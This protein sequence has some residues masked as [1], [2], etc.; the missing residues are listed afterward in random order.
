MHVSYLCYKI[1]LNVLLPGSP[2]RNIIILP[3]TMCVTKN[4]D[5]DCFPVFFRNKTI[6]E[7][8]ECALKYQAI[9]LIN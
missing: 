3:Y 5:N 2:I 6:F 9:I 1:P 8:L 4:Y 7:Q